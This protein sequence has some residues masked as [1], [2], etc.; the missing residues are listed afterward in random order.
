MNTAGAPAAS[1]VAANFAGSM[2]ALLY[3]NVGLSQSVVL[4]LASLLALAGYSERP[5]LA[6]LWFCLMALIVALRWR[7]SVRYQTADDPHHPIWRTRGIQGAV[8]GSGGWVLGVVAFMAGT[9]DGLQFFV[10][11]MIAGVVAGGVPTLASVPVAYRAFAVP[12]VLAVAVMMVAQAHSMLHWLAAVAAVL[13]IL[14]LLTSARYFYERLH[15]TVNQREELLVARDAAL[16]GLRSKSEFLANMSHEIRTPMNGIIGMT[17]LL[18]QTRLD[19]EQREY[20]KTVEESAR[21]LLTII[22]DILDFSKIEAGKLTIDTVDFSLKDL[23]DGVVGLVAPKAFDKGLNLRVSLAPELPSAVQGDPIRLRQ[24]LLNL[25]GNAVKFTAHGEV[26]LEVRPAPEA[27]RDMVRFKVCDTGIGIA[28]EVQGRLFQSFSQADGSTTRR[29]GGTG[30][31]LAI[32]RQLVSLMGGEIGVVSAEGDGACFWFVLPLALGRHAESAGDA[33]AAAV[34]SEPGKPV[35]RRVLLVEDN[36]VNQKVAV[37]LLQKQG[38]SVE[39]V[40]NGEL[41]VAAAGTD[42]FD[43]IFMDCQM[44]VMDGFTATRAIRQA[45]LGSGRHVPIIALTA[46]AMLGD[47][48]C[49]L[50]AGMDDY[51]SKPINVAVLIETLQRWLPPAENPQ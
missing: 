37:K 36:I 38:C 50:E 30:L 23:V 22:N 21:A 7:T 16:A 47:R 8:A 45:E 49:C 29:Y 5:W 1:P 20:A 33:P 42:R 14:V 40:E 6:L 48:E 32:S 35:A 26:S 46:N 25:I 28:P 31:G 15:M 17:D 19:S 11:F 41:A 2:T 10:A 43:A 13:Y 34:P 44:P 18:L 3:R 51:L 4:V 39:V 27:G 24:I 9:S 12:P